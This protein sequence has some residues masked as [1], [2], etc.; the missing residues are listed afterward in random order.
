[1]TYDD[2]CKRLNFVKLL[3]LRNLYKKVPDL[4]AKAQGVNFVFPQLDRLDF[5]VRFLLHVYKES[6]YYTSL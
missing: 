6:F 1:M 2:R 5:L 4:S 3:N